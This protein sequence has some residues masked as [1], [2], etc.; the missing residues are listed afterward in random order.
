MAPSDQRGHPCLKHSRENY[1]R[2]R[3]EHEKNKE[4]DQKNRGPARLHKGS[5]VFDAVNDVE[6]FHDG[7]SARGCRPEREDKAEGQQPSRYFRGDVADGYFEEI[8]R[9]L[10]Q[11]LAKEIHYGLLQVRDRKG[12]KKRK[13]KNRRGENGEQKEIGEHSR[14]VEYAVVF[15]GGPQIF[16]ETCQSS[17]R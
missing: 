14:A 2:Q 4:Q 17:L 11:D 8:C 16:Y 15:N 5:V 9:L 6:L 12:R 1:Q 10:G 13:G 7:V 3:A